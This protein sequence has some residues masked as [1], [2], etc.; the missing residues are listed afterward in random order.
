MTK[1]CV[2]TCLLLAACRDDRD[3]GTCIES[4][5]GTYWCSVNAP[6]YQCESNGARFEV[7]AWQQGLLR[8]RDLGF[9]RYDDLATAEDGTHVDLRGDVASNAEQALTNNGWVSLDRPR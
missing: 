6:R 9:T 2:L 4:Y 3:R 8:C 1:A 7:E 5:R